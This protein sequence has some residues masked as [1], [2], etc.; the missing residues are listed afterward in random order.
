[1]RANDCV[2]AATAET[3]VP[4][5]NSRNGKLEAI[6][7]VWDA[8]NDLEQTAR[9]TYSGTL[10]HERE[11]EA[12]SEVSRQRIRDDE[13]DIARHETDTTMSLN[14]RHARNFKSWRS[15]VAS[16]LVAHNRTS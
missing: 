4:D 13:A 10:P 5:R 1:M 6:L 14:D 7:Q 12:L 15:Y 2:V 11:T 3:T 8:T 9:K 16:V